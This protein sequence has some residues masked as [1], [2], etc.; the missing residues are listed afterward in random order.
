M[1]IVDYWK[2]KFIF[3]EKKIFEI[4][5]LVKFSFLNLWIEEKKIILYVYVYIYV[6]LVICL[7]LISN[8]KV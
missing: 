6:L 3:W 2:V 5:C 8:I 1:I 7:N 4:N